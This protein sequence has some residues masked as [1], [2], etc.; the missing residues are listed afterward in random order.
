M[1]QGRTLAVP[2][3]PHGPLAQPAGAALRLCPP[4]P[5][6]PRPDPAAIAHAVDI[7]RHAA[8]LARCAAVRAAAVARGPEGRGD[9]VL[10]DML[11][12]ADAEAWEARTRTGREP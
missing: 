6:G 9:V 4:P 5:S 8:W 1:S 2:P 10:I 12:A 11:V 7:E 3:Q